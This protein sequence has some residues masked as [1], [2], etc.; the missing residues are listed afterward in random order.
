MPMSMS[1]PPRTEYQALYQHL[2]TQ[3]ANDI[4][5]GT[6]RSGGTMPGAFEAGVAS[7]YGPFDPNVGFHGGPF[8]TGP[9]LI[10]PGGKGPPPP[11]TPQSLSPSG[12]LSQPMP[13]PFTGKGSMPPPPGKGPYSYHLPA[14]LGAAPPPPS[15]PPP[16]YNCTLCKLAFPTQNSLS[17]HLHQVHGHRHIAVYGADSSYVS[18]DGAGSKRG[19]KGNKGVVYKS[20]GSCGYTGN[21]LRFAWCNRC[22]TPFPIASAPGYPTG[23]S[24]ISGVIP[25]KPFP[26]ND[27]PLAT[28]YTPEAAMHYAGVKDDGYGVYVPLPG[29]HDVDAKDI[30]PPVMSPPPGQPPSSSLSG[31]PDVNPKSV[32]PP[33]MS[34]PPGQPSNVR[35]PWSTPVVGNMPPIASSVNTPILPPLGFGRLADPAASFPPSLPKAPVVDAKM[36]ST[37]RFPIPP[38]RFEQWQQSILKC[39][40]VNVHVPSSWPYWFGRAMMLPKSKEAVFIASLSTPP[41]WFTHLIKQAAFLP[42]HISAP[43]VNFG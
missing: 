7:G 15:T 10:A 37:P 41:P 29:H 22:H 36:A 20:C 40:S 18:V 33:A 38:P 16:S 32:Y 31:H 13:L 5:T 19:S 25:A 39:A 14:H 26:P 24:G 2:M 35:M 6:L 27:P 12:P 42:A 4:A 17:L 9:G 34:P 28:V 11:S 43:F 21:L 30:P 3:L 1:S 8:D 23:K